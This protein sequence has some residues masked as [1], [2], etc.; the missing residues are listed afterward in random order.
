M[1]ELTRLWTIPHL[2]YTLVYIRYDENEKK[3]PLILYHD[4]VR[5]FFY[6]DKRFNSKIIILFGYIIVRYPKLF[7]PI[8]ESIYKHIKGKEFNP[9]NNLRI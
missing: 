7:K 3:R 6:L 8:L 1:V 4:I 9:N 2:I 5:S